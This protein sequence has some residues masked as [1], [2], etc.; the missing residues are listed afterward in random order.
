MD[1]ILNSLE[2]Q[3]RREKQRILEVHRLPEGATEWQLLQEI[4]ALTHELKGD[5]TGFFQHHR[6]LEQQQVH[7]ENTAPLPSSGR[8]RLRAQVT[9]VDSKWVCI[10]V[11]CHALGAR[12]EHRRLARVTYQFRRKA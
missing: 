11:H 1:G 8:L 2:K 10:K 5:L 7:L 3:K 9:S 4:E 6:E 12:G